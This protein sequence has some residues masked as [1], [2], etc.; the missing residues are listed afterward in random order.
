MKSVEFNKAGLIPDGIPVFTFDIEMHEGRDL[1]GKF[2]YQF[3]ALDRENGPALALITPG[4]T[5]LAELEYDDRVEELLDAMIH[6]GGFEVILTYSGLDWM[7]DEDAAY[8]PVV[9]RPSPDG[10]D[11]H[12]CYPFG[13]K[14]HEEIRQVKDALDGLR[15]SEVA[16]Q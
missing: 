2:E 7:E 5:I 10:Q 13:P 15:D 12:Q 6:H 11:V 3:A 1:D 9:G 16:Q 4:G 14:Q 8:L